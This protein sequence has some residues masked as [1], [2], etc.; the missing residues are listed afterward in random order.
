[1][2]V[3]DL[4]VLFQH[5]QNPLLSYC[6][7]QCSFFT[8]SVCTFIS[9]CLNRTPTCFYCLFFCISFRILEQATTPKLERGDRHQGWRC[10][11]CFVSKMFCLLVQSLTSLFV[12]KLCLM[13]GLSKAVAVAS[14]GCRQCCVTSTWPCTDQCV[15]AYWESTIFEP[16]ATGG[17]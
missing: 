6:T 1:M 7:L 16:C 14:E 9:Y 13:V 11:L 3:H 10:C 4:N 8:H 15:Q 5:D 12:S 2:L 17:V